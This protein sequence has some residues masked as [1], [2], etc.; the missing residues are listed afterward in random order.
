[1]KRYI[2]TIKQI[3]NT[4]G[5]LDIRHILA[6][7]FFLIKTDSLFP[8]MRHLILLLLLLSR[9][10][11]WSQP[12]VLA[13]DAPLQAAC[14]DTVSVEIRASLTNF[15]LIALQMSVQ[16]DSLELQL[17]DYSVPTLSANDPIV[18][19]FFANSGYLGYSWI[20]LGGSIATNNT[21][22]VTLRFRVL[23]G[24]GYATLTLGDFPTPPLA[25]DTAFNVLEPSNGLLLQ[26]DSIR[27][28]DPFNQCDGS[29]RWTPIVQY[30]TA[31]GQSIE[32]VQTTLT[33]SFSGN[34]TSTEVR[35]AD[36]TGLVAFVEELPFLADY[37]LAPKHLQDPLN[38]V[39]AYDMY[40][41][42]RHLL[43][44]NPLN[45]PYK[46]LAADADQSGTIS[47]MD[48]V[49]LRQLILGLVP[50]FPQDRSWIFIP[51]GAVFANPQNPFASLPF[52]FPELSGTQVVA[53]P[54]PASLTGIKLGD[55][56]GSAVSA[57]FASE[58]DVQRA[59]ATDTIFI[60][61][62]YTHEHILVLYWPDNIVAAQFALESI[63]PTIKSSNEI[64]PIIWVRDGNVSSTE[65]EISTSDNPYKIN[66]QALLAE[67]T[68]AQGISHPVQLKMI[69][70]NRKK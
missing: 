47:L 38:G 62:T 25:A 35:Y 16:W 41:L 55:L 58:G 63:D 23:K 69:E 15:E 11:V 14:G 54:L 1:V 52:A 26:S 33:T 53:P 56:N 7:R 19:T 32:G 30:N 22:I 51:S 34:Y 44:T 49:Y 46:L 18:G 37:S 70:K 31:S 50:N 5:S 67:A 68:D 65:V 20:A 8:K 28:I 21:S 59:Q 12:Y 13:V 24:N 2:S 60:D 29:T 27:L 45:T 4:T 9:L 39:T 43:G 36:A 64:I 61:A 40:L 57:G 6:A 17:V 66:Y 10:S 48:V 42:Q 3:N